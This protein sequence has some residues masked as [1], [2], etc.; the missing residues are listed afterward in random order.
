MTNPK[1]ERANSMRKRSLVQIL[2][3]D[4][5]ENLKFQALNLISQRDFQVREC[6]SSCQV[7]QIIHQ[8]GCMGTNK[9]MISS[10]AMDFDS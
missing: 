9:R 5:Q 6:T 7:L 1:R 2:R 4:I 3:R 10:I 8:G